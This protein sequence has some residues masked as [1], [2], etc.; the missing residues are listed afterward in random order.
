M[1]MS[2]ETKAT[3]GRRPAGLS[4]E[5]KAEKV[6]EYPKITLTIKRQTKAKLEAASMLKGLPA[7]RIVDEAVNTFVSK[8]PAADREA[9]ESMV[10]RMA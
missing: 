5:G 1:E 3:R 6:S 10:Q 8:L 7:W 9:I 2:I 4:L